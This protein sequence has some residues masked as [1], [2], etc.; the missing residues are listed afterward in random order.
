MPLPGSEKRAMAADVTLSA[1]NRYPLSLDVPGLG[2]EILIPNCATTDPY[3]VVADAVTNPVAVRPQSEVEIN[4]RGLIQELPES[5][6]TVCPDSNSSPLDDFLRQY[7]RGEPATVFVRGQKRSGDAPEWLGEIISSIMV[8]VPFPGR[9]FDD[10]IRSFELSDV[11]FTLPDPLAE[12]DD[13]EA[14]PMVSATVLV[15]A[16]LPA[17]MN[18]DISVT[19]I[20]ASSDVFYRGDKLGELSLQTWQPANSTRTLPTK[21]HE[22][23]LT[24]QSRMDDVPLHVTDEDVFTDVVQALIFGGRT[25]NLDVNALVDVRVKTVLGRFELRGVPAKGKVPVKRPY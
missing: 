1:F 6:T 7:V 12:P 18:F 25:V 5:L 19:R 3:I 15:T 9:T 10:L 22:A 13:P 24:I 4:V 16:G 2:F 11:H 21:D 17:E 20:R 8:P 14:Q 23:I